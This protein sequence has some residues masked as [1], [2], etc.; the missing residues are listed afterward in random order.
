MHVL[1]SPIRSS[2]PAM[3]AACDRITN[4]VAQAGMRH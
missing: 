2:V 1:V 3:Y 4:A